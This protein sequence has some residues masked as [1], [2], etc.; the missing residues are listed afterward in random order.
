M[1]GKPLPRATTGNADEDVRY[2]DLLD[3]LRAPIGCPLLYGRAVAVELLVGTITF[4]HYLART[5]AGLLVTDQTGAAPSFYR[6][7]WDERTITLVSAVA[8]TVTLW[9]F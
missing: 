6:T 8:C 3:A 9:V 2:L 7:A 5:P 4:N 1:A